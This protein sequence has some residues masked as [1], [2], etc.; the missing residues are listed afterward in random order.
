MKPPS[1]KVARTSPVRSRKDR[2]RWC[3]GHVGREHE[4]EIRLD[5]T[6]ERMRQLD[7]RRFDTRCRWALWSVRGRLIASELH[8]SCSHQEVCTV[9]GKATVWRVDASKCPDWLPRPEGPIAELKCTCGDQLRD[10]TEMDGCSTC[11]CR[12]FSWAGDRRTK[13]KR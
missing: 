2:R 5:K 6:T 3:G 1:D 8:W 10:H 9:C 12:G 4:T 13:E 7:P 11:G